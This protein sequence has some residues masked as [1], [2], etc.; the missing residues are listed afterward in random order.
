MSNNE[1]PTT[2]DQQATGEK[3]LEEMAQDT[4]GRVERNSAGF[5]TLVH[6]LRDLLQQR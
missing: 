4:G 6:D 2:T 3:L 5:L 1:T